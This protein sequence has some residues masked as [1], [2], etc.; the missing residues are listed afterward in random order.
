MCVWIIEWL[1]MFSLLFHLPPSFPPHLPYLF[2]PSLYYLYFVTHHHHNMPSTPSLAKLLTGTPCKSHGLPSMM[3]TKIADISHNKRKNR[4]FSSNP[5][6]FRFY[7]TFFKKIP[8]SML[9][10]IHLISSSYVNEYITRLCGY[11]SGANEMR[12]VGTCFLYFEVLRC[13][14]RL[15]STWMQTM[16]EEISCQ[17]I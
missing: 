16:K 9:L 8:A 4:K 10:E 6:L 14:D 7:F 17:T 2:F 13:Y 5:I 12:I 11:E 15:N 1:S 3:K